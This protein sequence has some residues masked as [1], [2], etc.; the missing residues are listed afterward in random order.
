MHC[1]ITFKF[2]YISYQAKTGL[3]TYVAHTFIMGSINVQYLDGTMAIKL[4]L[5]D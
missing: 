4:N 5:S 2:V 3:R 1:F